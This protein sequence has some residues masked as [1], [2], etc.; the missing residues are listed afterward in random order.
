VFPSFSLQAN[1]GGADWY[2]CLENII[3][4]IQLL[5]SIFLLSQSSNLHCR[6]KAE[7]NLDHSDKF[8]G[9]LIHQTFNIYVQT[10]ATYIRS[11][12]KV[13]KLCNFNFTFIY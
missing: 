13:G 11:L 6:Y 3:K 9:N 12:K 2:L 8:N 4:L 5:K 7:A 10:S 1:V